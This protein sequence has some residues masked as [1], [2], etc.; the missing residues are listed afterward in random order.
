MLLRATTVPLDFAAGAW[1]VVP[2]VIGLT[3]GGVLAASGVLDIARHHTTIVPH[4]P[5]STLVT[6]GVYRFTRNP[7]YTGLAV[8]YLGGALLAGSGWPVATLGFA[9]LAVRKL[10]IDPEE[11]YLAGKF[12]RAYADY[13]ARV[14]RWL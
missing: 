9:L 4:Q 11:S 3:A 5:V 7:M 10:V 2:G 12:G 8:A 14:R 1:T 13:R 6:S